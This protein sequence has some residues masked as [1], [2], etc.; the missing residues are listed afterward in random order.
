MA[1]YPAAIQK[2]IDAQ[3]LSGKRMVA[4][5]R[6]NLHVAVSEAASLLGYFNQPSR[7][8]SH[9]YVRRDGT[10]E[11][12]VDTDFRAE[13]DLDGNDASISVETQGGVSDAQGEPWTPEQL[14]ALAQLYA[15]AI[16]TH[17]VVP[18]LA[19]SSRLGVESKGLSSHRLGI[20]PYRVSDGMRYSASYGKACPGD[21]KFTQVADVFALATGT[22][23]HAGQPAPEPVP[24]PAPRPPAKSWVRRGETGAL[25]RELQTLLNRE[26]GT[27]LAVDA[28]FGPATEA[29]VRA[30]QTSR[31]LIID[32]I[33]GDETFAALRSSKPAAYTPAPAGVLRRGSSGDQVRR[34]QTLLR[35]GY[36][37]YASKL[38]VDGLFGPATEAVVREFQ[39]RAGLVVDGSVG[40]ATRRALGL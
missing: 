2:P 12:Y 20:D 14:V 7:P 25:V 38:V 10:V 36:P 13:A 40:P 37:L 31:G 22:P 28:S 27:G 23:A 16:A 35:T 18:A 17:A 26:S 29:A 24:Q 9:F 4:F 33:A 15:W 6:V 5:N 21:R 11:Q 19:V 1:K 39:R 8:S 34:L 3:F 32:G 30:Y